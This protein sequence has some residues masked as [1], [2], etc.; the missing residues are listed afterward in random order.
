MPAPEYRPTHQN[1]GAKGFWL[2][3]IVERP[4]NTSVKYTDTFRSENI[5]ES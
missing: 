3:E 5:D 4:K 1:Q 2:G